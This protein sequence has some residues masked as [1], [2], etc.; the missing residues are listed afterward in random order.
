MGTRI[1]TRGVQTLTVVSVAGG[2]LLGAGMHSTSVAQS[3]PAVEP[4]VQAHED[5]ANNILAS[6]D[7]AAEGEGWQAVPAPSWDAAYAACMS[8]SGND[9][10][11]AVAVWEDSSWTISTPNGV[12]WYGCLPSTLEVVS[13]CQG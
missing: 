10:D 12:I 8:G 7:V 9:G 1:T 4:V 6:L 13:Y 11:Y 5:C 2:I 3:T